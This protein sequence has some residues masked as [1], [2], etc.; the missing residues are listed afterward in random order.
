[1]RITDLTAT[2]ENALTPLFA[3]IGFV[4]LSALVI[5]ATRRSQVAIQDVAPADARPSTFDLRPSTLIPWRVMVLWGFFSLLLFTYSRSFYGHYYIQLAA[6]LCL[7]GAGA[8]LLSRLLPHR[9]LWVG[10]REAKWTRLVPVALLI[11]VALPLA[12]VQWTRVN[13][14]HE[15]RVF[16]IVA[17]YVTDAV[18]PGA[19]VLTTDEQFNFLAARPPSRNGTGYLVDSYGHMIYLGL[20]LDTR[21]LGDLFGAALRGDHG[22]NDAYAVLQRPAAQADFLNR[23]VQAPLIVIHD[24]GFPRLTPA[25]LQA[26]ETRSTVAEQQA[27]YTIYRV[28]EPEGE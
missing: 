18:P 9:I 19:P 1:M 6:P 13:S 4:T 15:N 2:F 28:K 21:D 11:L 22:G 7:L 20:G 16:E 27:K 10:Q 5:V 12:L 24:K 14:R 17:R 23:A 26:I 3:A 8:A 25:T